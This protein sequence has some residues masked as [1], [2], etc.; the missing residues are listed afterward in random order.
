MRDFA[1]QFSTNSYKFPLI[2]FFFCILDYKLLPGLKD[3]TMSVF[4]GLNIV[5]ETDSHLFNGSLFN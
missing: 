3:V 5:S 2:F 1:D 4:R